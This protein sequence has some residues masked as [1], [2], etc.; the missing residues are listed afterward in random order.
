ML[1]FNSWLMDWKSLFLHLVEFQIWN[2]WGERESLARSAQEL[3]RGLDETWAFIESCLQLWTPADCAKTFPDE[4]MDG[5]IYDVS[6]SWVIYHVM[7]HDLHHGGEVSL[8]LGMNGL[9]TLDL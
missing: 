2:C 3:A 6:R 5:K 1:C 7:E 9:Q 4:G 8:I